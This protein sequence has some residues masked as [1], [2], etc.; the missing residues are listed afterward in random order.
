MA[1]LNTA[2]Q[3]RQAQMFTQCAA[4]RF[5]AIGGILQ[6]VVD[7]HRPHLPR[8]APGASQKQGGGVGTATEGDRKRKA[9]AE[10]SQGLFKGL[11]HVRKPCGSPVGFY[12]P[13]LVSVKR[14]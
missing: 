2:H 9:R 4:M 12:L 8:P 1:G 11:S 6:A 7:V 14:P 10:T 3:Q 5:K 13:A